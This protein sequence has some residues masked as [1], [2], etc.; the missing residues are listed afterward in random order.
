MLIKKHRTEVKPMK[1]PDNWKVED[2][3]VKEKH[4]SLLNIQLKSGVH[5]KLLK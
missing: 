1:R 5:E 2:D 3:T 4:D